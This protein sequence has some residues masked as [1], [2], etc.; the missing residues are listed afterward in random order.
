MKINFGKYKGKTIEEIAQS[1]RGR[2]YLRWL[3]DLP[4]D[5]PKYKESNQKRRDAIS[6]ELSKYNGNPE[7]KNKESSV[8]LKHLINE[9][10]DLKV[11]VSRLEGEEMAWDD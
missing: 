11:R 8:D 4:D 5:K 2:G 3:H 7:T 10:Q 6:Q 9:I 1:E